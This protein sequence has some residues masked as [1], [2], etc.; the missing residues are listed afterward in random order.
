MP[1]LD[2]IA[3]PSHNSQTSINYRT[4]SFNMPSPVMKMACCAIILLCLVQVL[5]SAPGR[6]E[7]RKTTPPPSVN[8]FDTFVRVR[9]A[10]AARFTK[11]DHR[12]IEVALKARRSTEWTAESTPSNRPTPPL[13]PAGIDD[14]Q[15]RTASKATDGHQIDARYIVPQKTESTSDPKSSNPPSGDIVRDQS[16]RTPIS[17]HLHPLH[18]AVHE[19]VIL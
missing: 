10:Q 16:S 19:P 12:R 2:E 14:M 17:I 9:V 4:T 8:A 1:S 5:T 3:L 13:A 6:V 18:V 7:R 15:R 11:D